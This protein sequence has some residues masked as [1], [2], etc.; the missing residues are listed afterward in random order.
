MISCSAKRVPTV[1]PKTTIIKSSL[2]DFK[3]EV[4]HMI[5]CA[6][7]EL[8]FYGKITTEEGQ[9]GEAFRRAF[10]SKKC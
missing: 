2:Y 3:N 8:S 6:E 5:K 10:A 1:G 9:Y 4:R 7:F